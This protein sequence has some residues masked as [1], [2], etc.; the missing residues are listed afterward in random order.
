MT[1][2]VLS[3]LDT[4]KTKLSGYA[5]LLNYRYMNLCVNAEPAALLSF[6]VD[7]DGEDL[8][9]EKTAQVR[10]AENRED[11][12][13]IFPLHQQIIGSI[14]KSMLKAHPEF[15]V[16]CPQME[17]SDNP[18]DRYIVA[19]MPEVDDNRHKILMDGVGAL[20]DICQGQ[21]DAAM[22]LYT[23]KLAAMLINASPETQ[24]EAKNAL[25][26]LYD[27]HEDMCKKFRA[28]KE[29]EIEDAYQAYQAKQAAEQEN[30]NGAAAN[31]NA[32]LQMNFDPSQF[33]G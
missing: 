31:A 27:E 8:P 13:E 1:S 11:Q 7:V 20:A 30:D 3:L 2:G 33:G 4:A 29:Q 5:A 21:M 10:L 26:D 24:D 23:G 25:Q 16:D 17:G 19:T 28:D 18:E 12:F 6:N 9:I 22:T 32:G 15:K 14:V